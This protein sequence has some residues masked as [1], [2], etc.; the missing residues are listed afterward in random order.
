MRVSH[1]RSTLLHSRRGNSPAPIIIIFAALG[2]AAAVFFLYTKDK[3]KPA[4]T[5]AA[6]V[7]KAGAAPAAGTTAATPEQASTTA[8]AVPAM[9]EPSAPPIVK[10]SPAVLGFARP[11][12]LASYFARILTEGDYAQAAKMAG[13]DDP[14]EQAQTAA[15]LERIFKGM[16][17]KVGPEDKIQM[18]GQSGPAI[19][20]GIPLLQPGQTQPGA[21]LQID[22]ERHLTIGWKITQFYLPKELAQALQSPSGAASTAA[23]TASASG[24]PAMITPGGKPSRLFTV[25]DS[26]DALS[27]ASQF[28]EALLKQDFTAARK[29]IDEKKVT[30]QKLAGLCIVFEEGK[31]ELKQN[32]PLIMTSASPNNA[33]I[34]AQVESEPLQQQ[35]EFGVEM[36]RSS[37][38]KPWVITGLNLSDLLGSYAKAAGKLGVPY[39]PIVTNP[40][41]GESLA[42]YFEYDQHVLHPRARKQLEIVASLLKSNSSRKL[43]ITGHTDALG[44]DMYNKG[45]SSNRAF[46][47]KTELVA[48]GVDEAQII[49]EGLGKAAPISPNQKADGTDD[50]EGRSR[51]RRAEIFLDF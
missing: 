28:V 38:D 47:V 49:T 51:N 27:A 6:P 24:A 12:D 20:M 44:T 26:P 25:V 19:R 30:P 48:L 46:N 42:L 18:L 41:G 13:E 22:S 14:A 40:R 31:Y 2:V 11:Q 1:S 34:I 33:W 43:R 50:P 39:T 5:A 23:T 32:K 8:P 9:R 37:T 3:L 36:Q 35:T 29:S 4:N 16:G 45:L 21:Q 17:Y 10:K 15:T 7:T